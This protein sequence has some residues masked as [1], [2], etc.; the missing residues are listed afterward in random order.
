MLKKSTAIFAK[1]KKNRDPFIIFLLLSLVFHFIIFFLLF[2]VDFRVKLSSVTALLKK[3]IKKYPRKELPASLKPRKSNFGTSVYFDEPTQRIPHTVSP[4]E[5]IPFQPLKQ[6]RKEPPQPKPLEQ[7][8][9]E[10]KKDDSPIKK[11]EIKTEH[12]PPKQKEE[13]NKRIK[14]IKKK[15]ERIASSEKKQPAYANQPSPKGFRLRQPAF[16]QRLRRSRGYDGQDGGQEASVYAEATP[17]TSAGRPKR[18]KTQ[19]KPKRKNIIALTKGFLENLK[20][21]GNDLLERKGDDSKRPSFEEY[22]YLS[23]EARINWHLQAAW[24]RSH[25]T[26]EKFISGKAVI[27][28]IID[29]N[30]NLLN[31]TLLQ[32]SGSQK[33]DGMIIENTKQAAPFPPLPKHFNTT[34]YKTERIIHVSAHRFGF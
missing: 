5:K 28:L 16:A 12:S 29:Q 19:Q 27:D 24:K 10:E 23:Y 22:K 30:G 1:K 26:Q 4:Q 17:D 25:G 15:Q 33:L 31:V 34:T 6:E 9:K 21:E 14:S 13:S 18:Q 2:I 3:D 8:K 32:S 7:E 11:V 20:D